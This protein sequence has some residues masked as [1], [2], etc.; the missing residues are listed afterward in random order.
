MEAFAP[1][2]ASSDA[3]LYLSQIGA[4]YAGKT[5]KISLWDPGDTNG[6]TAT[7]SFLMPTS[8]G[9]V[10]APFT[11]TATR[12]ATSSGASHCDGTGSG[13][14]VT[15]YSGGSSRFNG[16]WIV[17][18]VKIPDGYNAPT[19]PGEPGPGW[20]KIRYH[21]GSGSASASDLTTWRTQ[22]VGNPVHLVIP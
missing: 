11:Y 3:D 1:L 8:T 20:W 10:S 22:L 5:L 2:E 4:A 18:S 12:V 14:S 13:T 7:L 17:F 6:L 19:P 16:C 9:Y 21:M 15:T